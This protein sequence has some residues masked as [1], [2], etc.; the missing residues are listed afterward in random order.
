MGISILLKFFDGFFSA[1]RY[2]TRAKSAFNAPLLGSI[3]IDKTVCL[4]A[5]EPSVMTCGALRAGNERRKANDSCDVSG[6]FGSVCPH[7]IPWKFYGKI[8]I[9]IYH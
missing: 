9:Y 3:L 7:G 2:N 5:P 8:I 6:L 1:K 4:N